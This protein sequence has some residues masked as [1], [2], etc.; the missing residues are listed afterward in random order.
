MEDEGN[1]A[2]AAHIHNNEVFEAALLSCA[3]P[4]WQRERWGNTMTGHREDPA[5]DR[6]ERGETAQGGGARQ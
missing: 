6:G 2:N 3:N 5:G 1:N 4:S